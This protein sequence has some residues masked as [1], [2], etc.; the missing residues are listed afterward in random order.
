MSQKMMM[1]ER[2][3][4][5]KWEQ[6]CAHFNDLKVFN[7]DENQWTIE[8]KQRKTGHSEGSFDAYYLFCSE[9]KRGKTKRFRSLKEVERKLREDAEETKEGKTSTEKQSPP[10]PPPPPP[11][12]VVD[13]GEQQKQQQQRKSCGRRTGGLTSSFREDEMKFKSA[14]EDEEEEEED[15]DDEPVCPSAF[16]KTTTKTM[17]G[18]RGGG[19]GRAKVLANTT[20]SGA[21]QQRQRQ[22]QHHQTPCFHP[23]RPPFHHSN[24]NNN[25]ISNSNNNTSAKTH[26]RLHNSFVANSSRLE[27]AVR[28]D[29]RRITKRNQNGKR[30][31]TE[32]TQRTGL[33]DI[34]SIR[35]RGVTREEKRG[36]FEHGSRSCSRASNVGKRALLAER[37]LLILL[38]LST[39]T[40]TTTTRKKTTKDE[41]D[42]KGTLVQVR[43]LGARVQRIENVQSCCE[44][45]NSAETVENIALQRYKLSQKRRAL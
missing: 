27:V 40:T 4:K 2:F 12:F 9:E 29:E 38:I 14:M 10:P 20:P 17:G 22:Q 25:N 31:E 6:F 33:E 32:E 44:C 45:G 19:L 15:E 8:V 41:D 16:L 26:S 23:S 3:Q 21:Q 35:C 43:T 42:E 7:F 36:L 39:T 30:K 5:A 11:P 24:N 13:E 34:Q 18:G 1:K 28:D 37:V